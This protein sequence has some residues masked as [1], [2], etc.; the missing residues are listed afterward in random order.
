MGG[1]PKKVGGG[2]TGRERVSRAKA[3]RAVLGRP[4]R[5]AAAT[6]LHSPFLDLGLE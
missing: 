3:V 1:L 4:L 6:F 2:S 5:P